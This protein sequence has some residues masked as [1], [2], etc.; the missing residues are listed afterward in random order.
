MVLKYKDL[1]V[2]DCIN[3]INFL[4]N[5]AIAVIGDVGQRPIQMKKQA[6]S[7]FTTEGYHQISS[8]VL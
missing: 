6:G 4:M 1:Q 7:E 2:A 3:K 5:E 8:V